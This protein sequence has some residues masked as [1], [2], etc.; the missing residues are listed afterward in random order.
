MNDISDKLITIAVAM[1][2]GLTF[3]SIVF[4]NATHKTITVAIIIQA[5]RS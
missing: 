3:L 2:A 4:V 1:P 5:I